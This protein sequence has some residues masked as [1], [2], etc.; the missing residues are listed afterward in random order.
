ME[1]LNE[2]KDEIVF[3]ENDTIYTLVKNDDLDKWKLRLIEKKDKDGT[4]IV[5]T[6]LDE[7]GSYNRIIIT[8]KNKS[9]E[10]IID[11]WIVTRD[12]MIVKDANEQKVYVALDDSHKAKGIT[13]NNYM[14]KEHIF[15]DSEGKTLDSPLTKDTM[16]VEL[17]YYNKHLVDQVTEEKGK[18]YE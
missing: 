12:R 17:Y 7:Y 5:D 2:D 15:K 10:I 18:K 4:I 16:I 9:R 6:S 13:I 8:Q 3:F 14:A 1:L 11:D